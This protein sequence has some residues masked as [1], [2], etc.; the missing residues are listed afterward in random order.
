MFQLQINADAVA[1]AMRLARECGAKVIL[2]PAPACEIPDEMFALADYVTPNETETEF[3]TAFTVIKRRSPNGANA[4]RRR[5]TH[6]AR[7]M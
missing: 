7:K 4:Q 1:R 5:F 6:A 3:F 2:N